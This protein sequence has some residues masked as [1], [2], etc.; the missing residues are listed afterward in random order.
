ML[1]DVNDRDSARLSSLSAG[2]ATHWRAVAGLLALVTAAGARVIRVSHSHTLLSSVVNEA[3]IFLRKSKTLST[4]TQLLGT[5]TA[6]TAANATAA[7]APPSLPRL[8]VTVSYA[9]LVRTIN[10]PTETVDTLLAQA[11]A[12]GALELTQGRGT[13]VD[14]VFTRPLGTDLRVQ[15]SHVVAVAVGLARIRNRKVGGG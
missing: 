9:T 11:Q 1:V 14:V 2:D 6:A 12:F 10:L 13:H 3:L 7:N 15:N 4:I 5:T 8:R